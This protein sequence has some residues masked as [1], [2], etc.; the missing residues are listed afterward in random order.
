MPIR[1]LPSQLVN[2]IAAGE[3]I[4]RPASVIKELLENSLDAQA[5]RVEIDVE[6]GGHRL[7][8]VRD[9]GVGIIKEDLE[10]ALSRHATSKISSMDDLESVRSLGFRGEALPSIASVSRLTLTSCTDDDSAGWRI[11]GDGRE[12]FNDPVPA[13]HPNGTTVDVRDLFFNVPARRKFLRTERTE[14]QH[15][16]EVVRRLS[17]SRFDVAI[18]LTHNGRVQY[19]F[20]VAQ[21]LEARKQRVAKVCGE[22]FSEQSYFIEHDGA[23]MQLWGWLGAPTFSRAQGDLQY[24]Y[25]NGRMVRDKVVSHAVRLAYQDVLYHGRYPAFV[26]FLEMDPSGVDVNAHP[27]KAEVRFRDARLIHDYL[28]HTLKEAVAGGRNSHGNV[29]SPFGSISQARGFP[30]DPAQGFDSTQEL[31]LSH[32]QNNAFLSAGVGVNSVENH[33]KGLELLY[34]KTKQELRADSAKIPPLGFALAQL[35]GIYIL[36]ENEHGLVL[37]DMHAA[38][39]RIT[40]ERLKSAYDVE[41]VNSQPLLLPQTVVVSRREADIAESSHEL[42][43]RLGLEIDRI[44][45]ESL[46]IRAVP[47]LLADTDIEQLLRDVLGD[48]VEHGESLRMKSKL[49]EVLSTM[50]CHGSVRA[51]RRLTL[52]EMNN[53]LRDMEHTE[54]SDQCNHGRPTWIQMSLNELD[55]LFMR[56]R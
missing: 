20:H 55:R 56:G 16:E 33:L 19:D 32:G 50:A 53:L 15:I 6:R 42:L 8:R 37:V 36:A 29:A 30:S 28:H 51:N 25:V 7:M 23:G 4:D 41:N 22:S 26:L 12:E 5:N 47:A 3:V 48:V 14:Y 27:A 10:L 45:P 21:T 17:L 40:Y 2:Q 52:D 44:G 54:R 24:F 43:H 13:A 38:H 1:K 9:N 46:R 31:R 39:E 49:N 35:G 11:S 34:A 18:R